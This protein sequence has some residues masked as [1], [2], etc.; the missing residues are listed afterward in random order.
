MPR[1]IWN[2]TIAFG[3]IAVPVKVHS[4]TESRTIR[5][6]E[7]HLADGRMELHSKTL[8]T[9]GVLLPPHF[10]RIHKSYI[11]DM[12]SMKGIV[13]QGAGKYAME[14]NGGRLLPISRTKYR[15]LKERIRS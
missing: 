15:E 10:E 2:G 3:L 6:Q 5:F 13:L 14:M 4:A 12:R 7:V 8:E 11:A 1:S 9:L